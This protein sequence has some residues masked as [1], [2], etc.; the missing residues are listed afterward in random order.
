MWGGGYSSGIGSLPDELELTEPFKLIAEPQTAWNQS[1]ERVRLTSGGR[2]GGA[3]PAATFVWATFTLRFDDASKEPQVEVTGPPLA[4]ATGTARS[5]DAAR[6]AIAGWVATLGGDAGTSESAAMG[7]GEID[8]RSTGT[9]STGLKSTGLKSTGL[10]S[11]GSR[12]LGKR[13]RRDG[14]PP[15][16][17]T[18]DLLGAINLAAQADGSISAETGVA[19]PTDLVLS[20]W[21]ELRNGDRLAAPVQPVFGALGRG[22]M[23]AALTPVFAVPDAAPLTVRYTPDAGVGAADGS[24]DPKP[25]RGKINVE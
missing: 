2:S 8:G 12:V 22:G 10:K 25:G 15:V 5:D 7:A 3:T 20:G 6:R 16:A 23:P 13:S 1:G 17:R 18:L 11:T 4:P 14:E 24:G 19:W 9:K 21:V